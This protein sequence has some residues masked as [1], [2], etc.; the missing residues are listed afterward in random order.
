M[1]STP[2]CLTRDNLPSNWIHFEAGALAKNVVTSRVCSYLIDIPH[3]EVLPPLSQFQNRAADAEGSW[4]LLE[5]IN[6]ALPEAQRVEGSRLKK[7]FENIFWP[8]M[9]KAIAEAKNRTADDQPANPRSDSSKID[10]MLQL[11]RTLTKQ[12]SDAASI[13]SAAQLPF[14]RSLERA[15][16]GGDL[17][18]AVEG[19]DKEV[20]NR[21]TE[22]IECG[23]LCDVVCEAL[24]NREIESL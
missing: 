23:L 22:Q 5:D 7:L 24:R 3:S 12:G 10:E 4:K 6:A 18:K 16:R 17:K 11:L 19:L 13:I 21:I 20:L 15:G 9:S 2:I 14:L 1:G 8:D